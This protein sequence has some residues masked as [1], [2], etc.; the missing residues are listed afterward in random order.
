[1]LHAECTR[2]QAFNKMMKIN[3]LSA[4]LQSEVPLDPRANPTGMKS[5][6]ERLKDYTDMMAPAGQL[7]ADGKYNEAC[8]IYDSVAARFGFDLK[9]SNALTMDDLRKDGGRK[10]AG[11]CDVTELARR[12]AEFAA[13]FASAYAAGAFSFEQQRQFSKDS[14]KL[15]ML[16]TSDP[17]QA[18]EEIARLKTKYG[19]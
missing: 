12:N 14:E 4:S 19:L 3:Q 9:T 8:K 10:K 18:C 2:D 11:G 5:S 1:M 15:N 13:A 7:L 16:A 6:Y 17:S